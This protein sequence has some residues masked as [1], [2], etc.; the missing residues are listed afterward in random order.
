MYVFPNKQILKKTTKKELEVE[1]I[2]CFEL[3]GCF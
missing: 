1:K 3:K 2:K